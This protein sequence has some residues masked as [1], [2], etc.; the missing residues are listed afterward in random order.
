[1][2]TMKMREYFKMRK[3]IFYYAFWSN[4]CCRL[5]LN[6]R[7]LSFSE[8]KIEE[9]KISARKLNFSLIRFRWQHAEWKNL[10]FCSEILIR[11]CC[12]KFLELLG[13][14]CEKVERQ[15]FSKL[16]LAKFSAQLFFVIATVMTDILPK[17]FP[18]RLIPPERRKKFER[19]LF[20]Y[21]E[22]FSWT[23]SKHD[24]GWNEILSREKR[25]NFL[26]IIPAVGL[27]ASKAQFG[28]N[29]NSIALIF[30]V[31]KTSVDAL[32]FFRVWE[33]LFILVQILDFG[34]SVNFSHI[35]GQEASAHLSLIYEPGSVPSL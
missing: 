31:M 6:I 3:R 8:G 35:L 22:S 11:N 5:L 32:Q 14:V 33:R 19:F 13:C 23:F 7:K 16:C 26:L 28:D 15:K 30:S 21:R 27:S 4:N 12:W 2:F 24:C 25:R 1:M 18:L 29:L 20:D 10:Q 17:D 9:R 34:E